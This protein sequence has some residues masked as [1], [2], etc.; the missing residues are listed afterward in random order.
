MRYRSF[1]PASPHPLG[2]SCDY[3][4]DSC[5]DAFD[6]CLPPKLY[7]RVP[8]PRRFPV[9]SSR[10]SPRAWQW[11]LGPIDMTGGTSAFTAPE[12]LR[13]TLY[14]Q[15]GLVY[16]HHARE[17]R[18]SDASVASPPS[19][20]YCPVPSH[21]AGRKRAAKTGPLPLREKRAAWPIRDAFHRQGPFVA[22]APLRYRN[23]GRRLP[24]D[25]SRSAF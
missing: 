3:P 21:G 12:P 19:S 17:N 16:S 20:R 6:R 1:L 10:L 8:V 5:L 18:T 25:L 13:R 15:D 22:P 7:E 14:E 9:R 4:V 2:L 23:L 24:V 11:A